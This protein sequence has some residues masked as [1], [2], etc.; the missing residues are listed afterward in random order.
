MYNDFVKRKYGFQLFKYLNLSH[1]I[2]IL[3]NKLLQIHN[4]SFTLRAMNT[5]IKARTN[6]V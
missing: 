6:S 2:I 3:K 4:Q 5:I 1:L